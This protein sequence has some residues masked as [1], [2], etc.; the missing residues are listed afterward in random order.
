MKKIDKARIIMK[1]TTALL[2]IITIIGFIAC[3]TTNV[4]AQEQQKGTEK[5]VQQVKITGVQG[6]LN[7]LSGVLGKAK[8]YVIDL[9]KNGKDTLMLNFVIEQATKSI[10]SAKDLLDKYD[11]PNKSQIQQQVNDLEQRLFTVVMSL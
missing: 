2:F 11:Y 1:K 6:N 8:S 3:S 7:E 9:E 4:V 5:Q 10:Q